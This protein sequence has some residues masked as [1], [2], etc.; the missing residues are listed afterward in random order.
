MTDDTHRLVEEMRRWVRT[1]IAAI[2]PTAQRV[3]AAA[4][5]IA[6]NRLPTADE[7]GDRRGENMCDRLEPTC[8]HELP[9]GSGVFRGFLEVRA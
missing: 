3:E 1:E 6:E 2:E 7:E 9:L 8:D 5:A 4:R